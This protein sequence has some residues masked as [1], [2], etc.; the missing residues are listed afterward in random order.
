MTIEKFVTDYPGKRLHPMAQCHA[1]IDNVVP[2]KS[3]SLIGEM[4][5]NK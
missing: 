5:A 2:L 4:E 3:E 1:Q